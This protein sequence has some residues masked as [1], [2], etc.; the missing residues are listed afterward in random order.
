MFL[1]AILFFR[2]LWFHFRDFQYLS[3]IR[4]TMD[5]KQLIKFKQW[6]ANDL[7]CVE[8]E[9]TKL[10]D[11]VS[12]KYSKYVESFSNDHDVESAIEKFYD[13]EQKLNGNDLSTYTL[14]TPQTSRI[15]KTLN[16]L[17]C[18]RKFEIDNNIHSLSEFYEH[19]MRDCEEYKKLNLIRSCKECRLL[20]VNSYSYG[21]HVKFE[22]KCE[23]SRHLNKPDWAPNSARDWNAMHCR[24]QWNTSR[25]CEGCGQ[26]F[27][28]RRWPGSGL[29][30]KEIAYYRHC[31][32]EC[33]EYKKLKLIRSCSA[34]N[35][36]FI[37]GLAFHKHRE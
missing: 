35:R 13:Y 6:L 27:K 32:D 3:F 4:S 23:L 18:G 36:K 15:K 19:C 5:L 7:V 12:E 1:N 34:C 30:R 14:Y 24:L 26:Q 22:S 2:L 21:Q 20:F 25:N 11:K 28:A 17:G 8:Q 37:N 31:F 29:I 10:R 16:C 33:E 9:N